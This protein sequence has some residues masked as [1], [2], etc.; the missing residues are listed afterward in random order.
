M[1]TGRSV[2]HDIKSRRKDIVALSYLN[3]W[4]G[5]WRSLLAFVVI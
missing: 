1:N 4:V 3:R 2:V 5:S